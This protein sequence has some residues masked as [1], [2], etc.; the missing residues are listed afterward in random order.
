MTGWLRGSWRQ[1]EHGA[2]NKVAAVRNEARLLSA[3]ATCL[4]QALDL[5][6]GL[7][8]AQVLRDFRDL[9]LKQVI[10]PILA[11]LRECVT[12]MLASTGGGALIGGVAG[13]FAG[14]VGAVPGVALGATLG[15]Q[16]G[17]L[18]LL[19]MGLKA[20]TEY[21]VQNMPE[22]SR[23]YWHGIREAW[24]AARL[25]PLP[26]QP[27]HVDQPALRHAADTLAR[28]H[29]AMLVLLLT[30]IVAYLAK[31]RGSI[32][33]LA[34]SVRGSKL[35]PGFA[36]WMVGNEGRLKAE[37]RLRST[38]LKASEK[39]P[40]QPVVTRR[41]RAQSKLPEAQPAIS[42]LTVAQKRKIASDFYLKSGYKPS[43]IETHLNGIDFTQPVE[44]V[45][46]PQGTQVSQWQVPGASQGN[47]YA[48][49]GTQ[50]QQLGIS[51]LGS[52]PV[53][54]Q[55]VDRAAVS[56]I[57][58]CEVEVLKTT[59][60]PIADTWSIPGQAVATEGAGLQMF[61][62]QSGA[63]SSVGGGQ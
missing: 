31:G 27:V 42:P 63:F 44:I 51:P 7:A 54:G 62:S 60:A 14:G 52:D 38:T 33:D 25:T 29:I 18:I 2:A 11:V 47:Y 24:L 39:Q 21:I 35:G 56:Y 49:P 55:I 32:G 43:R 45:K 13:A 4:Q 17:E 48:L 6:E 22:I 41:G 23:S 10:G 9:E 16:L 28:A 5:S 37:P 34:K 19:L 58:N 57:T 46:L 12:V 30:G 36:E 50:P 8:A 59:A 1:F 53:N 40:S 61:S 20:L 15:A 3:R 26:Q